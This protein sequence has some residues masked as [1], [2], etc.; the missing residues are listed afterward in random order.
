MAGRIVTEF[1]KD[2]D[3]LL[4]KGEDGCCYLY[5]TI[6]DCQKR[7]PDRRASQFLEDLKVELGVG[8]IA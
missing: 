3:T 4:D 6:A 7:T 8:F 5:K 1:H 2:V